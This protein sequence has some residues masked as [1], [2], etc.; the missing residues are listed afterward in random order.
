VSALDLVITRAGLDRFTA[1]Q[2]SDDINLAITAVGLT[3]SD[4]VAAPTLTALPG[5][6]R[7]VE[8]VSGAAVGDNIVHM[9]VRDDAVIGYTVRGFG[10]F[11]DDGTLF[12]VHSSP[13]PIFQKSPVTSAHLAIDIAFPTAEIDALS[14]GDTDFLNPPATSEVKG[15]VELATLAEAQAGA[16]VLRVITVAVLSA[17]LND[18]LGD[19]GEGVADAL[20]ALRARE[21]LGAGLVS[22]GGDLTANRTLT[23]EAATAV[24]AS[25]GAIA[26]K[27]LTPASLS[28]LLGR[29]V[30][31]AGLVTG[32]GDLRADRTLTVAAATVAE[33]LAGLLDDKALTPASL[34]GLLDRK[35]TGGGLVT[36]GGDL[37]ADRTLTVEAATAAEAFAGLLASKA[38]TPASLVDVLQV[39]A[40]KLSAANDAETAAGAIGDKAVTP[41]SLWSSPRSL[42]STF[43]HLQIPGTPLIL[44]WVSTSIGGNTGLSVTL[45]I[46]FPNAL[47][48]AGCSGGTDGGIDAKDNL[49]AVVSWTTTGVRVF[50]AHDLA[51]GLIV[52]AIGM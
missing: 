32:G 34:S 27:A 41:A 15:V 47:L 21:I 40:T 39:L 12:A 20:A 25:A 22:G 17:I 52:F 1:A 43:G 13:E 8:T 30:T 36:G 51:V 4:F 28:G 7:R 23:V 16:D 45:P 18:R 10:L 11:L 38:L 46:A 9:V 2:L 35:V 24:E 37:R 44:Q 31:G 26:N 29:K 14:F 50:T 3:A 5:E 48:W 19:L 49:P 6:F 42:G 33:A